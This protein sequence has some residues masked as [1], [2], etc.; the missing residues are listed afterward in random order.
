MRSGHVRAA[1]NIGC[2]GLLAATLSCL[3][4]KDPASP[5]IFPDDPDEIVSVSSEGVAIAFV[6][7]THGYANSGTTLTLARPSGVAAGDVM[8]AQIITE[9][10]AGVSTLS[11]WTLVRADHDGV[12]ANA[13]VFWRRATSS[14]PTGYAWRA[15]GGT[16]SAGGIVAYRNVSPDGDPVDVHGGQMTAG[17]ADI[18]APSITATAANAY[19]VTV[20][21][22]VSERRETTLSFLPPAAMVER[23]DVS[24]QSGNGNFRNVVAMHASAPLSVAGST[25]QRIARLSQPRSGWGQAIVLRPA[26]AGPVEPPPPGNGA[27]VARA[28][29]PYT[30]T[31]G[32]PVA[33][34]G[35][36]SSD[37]D[38]DALTYGWTFGNG[39]SAT[40]A[41]P[42]HTYADNGTYTVILTV[43]DPSGASSA[44]TTTATIANAP[45]VV[46]LDVSPTSGA[47]GQAFTAAG[48]FSDA[49]TGDAPWTWQIT[50]GDGTTQTGSASTLS[51][52]IGA[53]RTYSAAGSY[54]VQ[55]S[56]TDKDGGTGSA[57]RTVTVTA[58]GDPGVWYTDFSGYTTGQVPSDW[59]HPYTA[60]SYRVA[61]QSGSTG[62][63]VLSNSITATGYHVLRWDAVGT[64]ADVEVETVV[65][66]GAGSTYNESMALVARGMTGAQTF[67]SSRLDS[68]PGLWTLAR[69]NSGASQALA[70]WTNPFPAGTW[71]RHRFRV[72]GNVLRVKLWA[73]GSPEPA[74]WTLEAVDASPLGSGFA[75]VW[76][77]RGPAINQFDW[78]RVTR[79]AGGPVEPPPPTVSWVWSGAQTHTG[80]T[81][82]A[83]LTAASS[84]VRLR[85]STDSSFSWYS[86]TGPVSTGSNQ[87]ATFNLTG[88]S[89]NT[90]YFYRVVSGSAEDA[91]RQGAFRT[92][93][94]PGASHSFTLAFGSCQRT[95]S[96]K[97]IYGHIRATNPLFWL[98]VGDI[99][100]SDIAVNDVQ[101]FRA[102]YNRLHEMSNQAAL[103]RATP[104]VHVWDDHDGAGGNDTDGTKTGWP[105][106]KAA[107]RES[108]PHHATPAGPTGAIYHS[109]VVGRVRFIVSDLRSERSPKAQFD[110]ANK[111]MF[112]AAQKQHFKAEL[113]AARNQGQFIAWISTVP[114]IA[115]ATAGADHWGGY[116]TERR[117][118]AAY[119]E[120]LGIG[121]QMFV[122][123]GDMH[124][125]AIDSGMNNAWGG[126]PMFNAGP[127]DQTWNVKGGPYSFGP[128]T[129]GSEG[130]QFGVVTIA[131][132]GGSTIQVSFSGRRN[133]AEIS[134]AS[135]QFTRTLNG[136]S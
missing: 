44:D 125:T 108:F 35:S 20:F 36:A 9:G 131:D 95:D 5:D 124:A 59:S 103:Y 133:G 28:G 97:P 83:R 72:E 4:D 30:G 53:S 87:V 129:N 55:L 90:R 69:Y 81:V 58:G 33:F 63:K 29:G 77:R 130:E 120:S 127:I 112:G 70:T 126:F 122:L 102:A 61:E 42:S 52:P 14:E 64:Q 66:V 101:L 60:S 19:L 57:Q 23:Y 116:D 6:A 134:G 51:T 65:R 41:K 105:A 75:G 21:S 11:G 113:A 76:M 15:S 80:A 135:L 111:T 46:Q 12:N 54:T 48:S 92:L 39:A 104:I 93:P 31:E 25:G 74:S 18:V 100:Y 8:I 45:P 94:V 1:R 119:I 22:A 86:E 67:Y 98:Q 7:A 132:N 73:A 136:G 121:G 91:S 79:L 96:N 89:P 110:D 85:V 16:R 117:E 84:A 68:G 3:S 13:Y 38:G 115:P 27:P 2:I 128:V 107:Y 56:V 49:G 109:F 40:G 106:V 37:P 47:V 82:R 24:S 34:D 10:S 118:I 50:W 62:G 43:T 32:A 88:Q 71:V 78:V 99:H 123:T 114:W 17:S 26:T